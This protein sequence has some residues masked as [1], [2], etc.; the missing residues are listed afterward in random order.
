LRVEA[1]VVD[2]EVRDVG[3][4]IAG[5]GEPFVPDAGPGCLDGGN[6]PGVGEDG[7]LLGEDADA[8]PIGGDGVKVGDF[9]RAHVFKGLLGEVGAADDAVGGG[10]DGAGDGAELAEGVPLA[11]N[12]VDGI[13]VGVM[14]AE[15]SEEHGVAGGVTRGLEF[16]HEFLRL[17]NH[18][19]FTLVTVGVC[20]SMRKYG[21]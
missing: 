6:V 16:G 11:G 15:A 14:L 7:V 18:R 9:D 10:A 12:G 13:G 20:R 8:A 19:I 17:F 21:A 3:G 4:L 2:L 5:G 1:I